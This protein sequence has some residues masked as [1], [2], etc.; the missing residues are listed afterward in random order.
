MMDCRLV[1]KHLSAFVDA[2]LEPSPMLEVEE[3]LV[4]CEACASTYDF[5]CALKN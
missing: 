3:H 1:Q 4:R 2:E 5:I